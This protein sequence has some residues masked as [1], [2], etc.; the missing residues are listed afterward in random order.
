MKV[1]EVPE[2]QRLQRVMKHF[3]AN[4]EARPKKRTS[5]SAAIAHLIGKKPEDPGVQT[6]IS[7]MKN[8]RSLA[9]NE[10]DVP[11]YRF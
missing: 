6:V 11:Q 3:R 4:P 1:Q 5:L 8:N 9:F 2:Y 10:N 7:L